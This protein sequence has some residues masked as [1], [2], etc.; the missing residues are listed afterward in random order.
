[1]ISQDR[2]I[3]FD[4]S[5]GYVVLYENT[6]G[7]YQILDHELRRLLRH[8]LN[9]EKIDNFVQMSLSPASKKQPIENI[10]DRSKELSGDPKISFQLN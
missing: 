5:L 10:S 3:P 4:L 1:M 6:I 9:G 8:I 7:G 2:D